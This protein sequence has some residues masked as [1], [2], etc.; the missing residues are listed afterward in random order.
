MGWA[1]CFFV[2]LYVRVMSYSISMAHTY[3]YVQWRTHKTNWRR[4]IFTVAE[5][6]GGAGCGRQ[7]FCVWPEPEG[8]MEVR[9]YAAGMWLV[10]RLLGIYPWGIYVYGTELSNSHPVH[11]EQCPHPSSPTACHSNRTLGNHGNEQPLK[12]QAMTTMTVTRR[13]S[14]RRCRTRRRDRRPRGT[15]TRG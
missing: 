14:S 6:S 5:N 1:V 13:T 11:S 8:V 10:R 12:V 3:T 9:V 15:T 7:L 4:A 2:V